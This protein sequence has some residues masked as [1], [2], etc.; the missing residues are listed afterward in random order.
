MQSEDEF[1]Q[2]SFQALRHYASL[3]QALETQAYSQSVAKVIRYIKLDP[4]QTARQYLDSLVIESRIIGAG[5]P[6]SRVNILGQARL[7]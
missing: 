4:I 7:S 2:L 6:T 1:G 5:K 3:V